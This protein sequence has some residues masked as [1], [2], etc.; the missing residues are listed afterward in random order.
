[1]QVNPF[2]IKKSKDLYFFPLGGSGEIGMNFN[3][4]GYDNKWLIIDCGVSFKDSKVLGADVFMPNIDI[5]KEY[6]LNVCGMF[7]THAHEDHIGAVH[8]LWPYIKCPIYTTPFSAYLLKQRLIDAGLYDK[9]NLKIVKKESKFTVGPFNLELIN[10]SHSILEANSVLIKVDKKKVFHT[11]DWKIDNNPSIGNK[12]NEKR[13]REIGKSGVNAMICDSTNANV[14]GSS[15][16]EQSIEKGILNQVE[17]YE[18]RIFVAMFASNV[19][20]ILTLTRIAKK[21]KRKMGAAGRSMWRMIKASKAVGYLNENEEFND[22]RRL[23]NIIDKEFLAICT[24]SQGEPLGALNRMIDDT[25]PHLR[26]RKGDRVIF[27]S[28]MIPGNEVSINNLLNKLIYKGVDV[29]FPKARDIHVSGHP[30][31][32]ELEMMYS[33]IK[34]TIL[35]PVHGEAVHIKAH[36]ELAKKNGIQN[37]LTTRNGQLIKITDKN[38]EVLSQIT[39]GKMAVNGDEIISTDSTLFKE[40]KKMLFN[41]VIALN[42]VFSDTGDLQELPR[43]KLL[44]VINNINQDELAKFS[45]YL[46][47]EIRYFIPFNQSKENQLREYLNKKIKKFLINT[48]DKNP[49][50]ILDIIYI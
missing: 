16:S 38:A 44:S 7:I 11:G 48:F 45:E 40:R 19:E 14:E 30:G 13:L 2:N 20:R 18:G 25:H 39:V 1:M 3:L 6:N 32:E 50:I 36:A 46:S 27:S 12:P 8:H 9:V 23:K 24:G 31:Q 37:V 26:L 4:Y 10:I 47:D 21:T 49:S 28:R 42:F 22:E 35:I 29:V 34:P 15:G 17:A 43:I 41:G 33:W 5:I